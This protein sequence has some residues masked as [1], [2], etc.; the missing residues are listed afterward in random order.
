LQFDVRSL[1]I[2]VNLDVESGRQL[3]SI[4][5][6]GVEKKKLQRLRE[7]VSETSFL[8]KAVA[9]ALS[10]NYANDQIFKGFF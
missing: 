4:N 5:P 6:I 1:F 9:N 2:K 8:L 3:T 10:Q 7:D